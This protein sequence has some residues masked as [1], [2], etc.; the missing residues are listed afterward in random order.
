MIDFNNKGFFKLK[1][2][3]EYA[4]R[5]TALLLDG[6]QVIDAY[7]SMRDGVVQEHRGLFDRDLGDVRSGFGA[8]GLFFFAG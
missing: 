4:D 3:N 6:E 7:K 5:V 1:Q 8:G 2:N